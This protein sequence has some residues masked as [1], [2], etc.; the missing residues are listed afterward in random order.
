[1]KKY[2]FKSIKNRSILTIFMVCFSFFIAS[3]QV[4]TNGGSGLAL[5]YP[6]LATA[7]LSLNATTISSPVIITLTGNETAPEGG[8]Q[9]TAQ[10]TATNTITIQGNASTITAS[11]AHV[12]G[13]R[14]DA[15]FKLIGADFITLQ[16][17]TMQENV[18]NTV[19]T[20]ASNTRTEFGVGLFFASTTNGSQNNT[21]QNNTISLDRLYQNS[22]GIYSNTNHTFTNG[23]TA[24]TITAL[25]GANSNNKFYS[26]TINNVNSGVTLIG[27]GVQAY[28][29]ENNEIGGNTIVS[30]NSITN[31]GSNTTTDASLIGSLA[32]NIQGIY[33]NHQKGY[34]VANNGITSATAISANSLRGIFQNYSSIDPTGTFTNNINNNQITLNAQSI[35]F[36]EHISLLGGVSTGVLNVTNNAMLNSVISGVNSSITMN[37][38]SNNSSFGIH[39]INNNT[40]KG[41]ASTATSG[42]FNGFIQSSGNYS[43]INF[44]NNKIGENTTPAITFSVATSGGII[45]IGNF[46]GSTN[47]TIN[48]SNNDF[49]GLIQNNLGS[50]AHT[51]IQNNVQVANLNVSDNTFTNIT[52]NTTGAITFINH[53]YT[54][55]ANGTQIF[56]NNRIVTNYSKTGSGGNIIIFSSNGSSPNGTITTYTNNNFSNISAIGTS[57][58]TGIS[59]A[60]GTT[61]SGSNRIVTGNT[62]SNWISSGGTIVGI[63]FSHI[64]ANSTI[65]NNLISNFTSSGAITGINISSIYAGGNPL[66]I[67]N[68]TITQLTTGLAIV[69]G[70]LILNNSPIINVLDNTISEIKGAGAFIR[71]ISITGGLNRTIN[72]NKISNLE[73]TAS[74]SIV[75]GINLL[76]STN[77]LF[78]IKNNYIGNLT[79]TIANNTGIAITGINMGNVAANCFI[80]VHNNTIYLNASSTGANFSTA[81]LYH[82]TNTTATISLLDMQN[83][84]F[85][86]NSVAKGTGKTV[87]YRRSNNILTNFA[88]TSNNNNFIAPFVFSDGTNF[89]ATIE[90]YKARVSPRETNSM[91]ETVDF[92]STNPIDATYLHINSAI[93][94]LLESRALPIASVVTDFDSDIRQGQPGYT[95]TGTAPDIGAD[96]FEGIACSLKPIVVATIT[97]NQNATAI[98]LT[99]TGTNLL[100]YT[101]AAG[102]TGTV[103]APTPLTTTVGTTSYWVTQSNINNCES[104]RVKIDVIVDVFASHLNFNA[105]YDYV[106]LGT[107]ISDVLLSTNKFTVEAWVYPTAVSNGLGNNYGMIVGNYNTAVNTMQFMLRKESGTDYAFWVNDGT[108]GYKS[109]GAVNS[110]TLN[111]WQHIAGVWDGS[112]IRIYINGVLMNTATGVTGTSFGSASNPVK[113]GLN[114]SNEKFVG[115]MDEVRIWTR[116]LTQTEI[117]RNMN[118]ELPAGQTNLLAY[119]KFNQ[120]YDAANNAAITTLTDSS[121]N[122]YDG[123]LIGFALNGAISNW[124]GGSIISS[125]ITIPNAPTAVAQNFCSATVSNL[126]PSPSA[127]IKWYT[128]A[129]SGIALLSTDI[130]LTGTYYVSAINANG[131]ESARTA[132]AITVAETTEWNGAWTNGLP[133]SGKKAI[134]SANYSGVGFAACTLDVIGTAIVV[135]PSNETLLIDGMVNV[136]ATASLTF[137]NNANLVQ[138]QNVTN[139]GNITTIRN[140]SPVMRL[141]YV[142]WSSPVLNQN[143][144][145]FSPA[146]LTNRFYKYEPSGTTTATSWIAIDPTSNTFS[147]GIGNLI[148]T[149]NTWSSTV[150]MMYSGSFTGVPNNGNYAPVVTL[151][152]NLLGNPYP[153]PLSGNS[154]IGNNTSIGATTLYFWAHVIP[155]TAGTYAQNNYASYTTA[156]GVAAAAGGAQPNGTIQ[157]GQGFFT[158]VTTAGNANFNNTQR[159][160][161]STGQFFRTNNTDEKHR[162]WLDLTSPNNLHNQMMVAYMSGATND[163][164]VA[165]GK[166]FGNTSSV[167]YNALEN[168]KYVIQGKALP[169]TDADFVPVGFIAANAGEFTIALSQ[170]DG[171]FTNQDIYLKDN[172]MNLTHDLKNAAYSFISTEGEFN[173]RFEIVYLPSMLSNPT[174]EFNENSVIVYKSNTNIEINSGAN[175]LSEVRI[176]DIRGRQISSKENINATSIRFENLNIQQEVLIVEVIDSNGS[177]ITKKIIF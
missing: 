57:A 138:N 41:W 117:Q 146:T 21:V 159:V 31:W 7:I 65:S 34:T 11:N 167:I 155:A 101:T 141:D 63:L 36:F 75:A 164:D 47:G 55:P 172:L 131:C 106:Y 26:N 16:N 140:S 125:G 64:G 105:T 176:L 24:V 104:T 71:G 58:I 54:I 118:C 85:T 73:G 126:L 77:S 111:A 103:I 76:S 163:V 15:I 162:L 119:Y 27:S 171:L 175:L 44:N 82:T 25:S 132:V 40:I 127:S 83:N 166:L 86:N 169:F 107:G 13:S 42:G 95:G 35:I 37:G 109:V 157:V 32:N 18:A 20:L 147:P 3:S 78:D 98:P 19:N 69:T 60:N 81:A 129:T 39:N 80:N 56:N 150:Y 115:N 148:R 8:Y 59:N 110:L 177:R 30:G 61:T 121:G 120:G 1:M 10:G 97:Y 168:D 112:E 102:G 48:I 92:L 88:T 113:M 51:Y 89:D 62:F 91:S 84:I 96:E 108:G 66:N 153:S 67:N 99:A 29:D 151:G 53:S 152:Y 45:G 135:I 87:A 100:W 28:M 43:T 116:A 130:L 114:N 23:N 139:I 122:N 68:N 170:F 9:I 134:I 160:T 79:N 161:S 93:P 133:I 142:A 90:A 12:V 14:T 74:N 94:N 158:N 5:N 6:D 165:D 154:F 22:F 49:R 136:A 137:S 173:N 124:L 50:G 17:F 143:L 145:S 2:Y 128:V 46:I 72:R 149:P 38:I 33:V 174:I 144:L 52:A 4:T 156:G 123:A 70:L